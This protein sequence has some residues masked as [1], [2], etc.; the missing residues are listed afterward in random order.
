MC[1]VSWIPRGAGYELFFS[2]DERLE[3][4]PEEPPRIHESGGT[5][6]IAPLDG[7]A[8]GTWLSV[9]QHGLSLGLL[10]GYHASSHPEAGSRSRGLLALDL[11]AS[12]SLAQVH[13]RLEVTRLA[14]YQPFVLLGLAPGLEPI[15]CD[16]D[17]ELLRIDSRGS[18][19]MPLASSG[20][21][22]R[23]AAR[24]RR[25]LL[26]LLARSHGRVDRALLHDFHASHEDRPSAFSPCM[27]RP[28]AE[29]RSLCHVVVEPGRVSMAHAPGPPCR[30]PLGA[31][32]VLERV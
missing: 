20:V 30:T 21:D 13:A 12:R 27:H 15:V 18:A 5:R 8:R 7:D 1:T 4:A 26:E 19:R 29:T 22:R 9:N 10:N 23:E 16:W 28:D 6:W 17:G 24:R 2:R 11:A 25:E 14:P 32:L 3:R 31:P